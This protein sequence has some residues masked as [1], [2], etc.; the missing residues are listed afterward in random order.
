MVMEHPVAEG[1]N[2]RDGQLVERRPRPADTLAIG[3]KKLRAPRKQ[4]L[5]EVVG[6]GVPRSHPL[7]RR[8]RVGE[9][10]AD[11][12]TELRR[13][14]FRER[15]DQDLARREPLLEHEPQEKRRDRVRFSGPRAGLDEHLARERDAERVECGGFAARRHREGSDFAAKQGPKT[16]SA[17]S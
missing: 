13:R 11:P 7:E 17:S 6:A 5:D 15:H 12:S 8:V 4:G 9:A 1:V 3:R 14:G 10:R 2:R 16:R